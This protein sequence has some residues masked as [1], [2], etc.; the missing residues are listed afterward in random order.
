MRPKGRGKEIATAEYVPISM[1]VLES[2]V[3]I[4]YISLVVNDHSVRN[5]FRD[6][7]MVVKRERSST[8]SKAIDFR[9]EWVMR[10]ECKFKRAIPIH[11]HRRA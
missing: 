5:I 8:I 7:A 9:R 2:N 11:R 6:I 3:Q 10:L 4:V 1:H